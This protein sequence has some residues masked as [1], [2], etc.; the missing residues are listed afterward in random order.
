MTIGLITGLQTGLRTGLRTGVDGGITSWPTSSAQLSAALGGYGTWSSIWT[1]D[2]YSGNLVD[3][4]GAMP[5]IPAVT[6]RYRDL[7]PLSPDFAVGF[8]NGS[9]DK[10]ALASTASYDI[11]ATDS[12]AIYVSMRPTN[13][14]NVNWVGKLAGAFGYAGSLETNGNVSWAVASTSAVVV[15]AP[16]DH[17]NQWNDILMCIDRSAQRIQVFTQLGTSAASDITAI[18]S[19]SNG[20]GFFLGAFTTIFDNSVA[21]LAVATG[22]VP[23]LRTN[24]AAAIQNIRRY[25]GR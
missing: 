6:P 1:C 20:A 13:A 25:T 11:T 9:G 2:E 16:G 7:G 21:Y 15:T 14:T 4:A 12:I 18:G 17:R 10:F 19:P 24:G 23:A 8:D 3:S 5:L 22:G